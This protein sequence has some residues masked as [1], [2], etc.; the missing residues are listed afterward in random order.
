VVVV[1]SDDDR[2]AFAGGCLTAPRPFAVADVVDDDDDDADDAD[3]DDADTVRL[4]DVRGGPAASSLL[5]AGRM[6]RRGRAAACSTASCSRARPRVT[7][8]MPSSS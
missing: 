3:V 6:S 2:D 8:S 4:N 5:A 1:L 7:R